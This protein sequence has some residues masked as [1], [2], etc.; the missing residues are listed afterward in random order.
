M[1]RLPKR[2]P[3]RPHANK[4][5]DDV[6]LLHSLIKT[7]FFKA[8][9]VLLEDDADPVR[10]RF[11]LT[12]ILNRTLPKLDAIGIQMSEERYTPWFNASCQAL[13]DL[14]TALSRKAKAGDA[15]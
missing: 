4:W 14:C 3:L 7:E 5:P 10:L 12:R 9:E 2:L 11:H 1:S 13:E 15:T 6:Q 8:T